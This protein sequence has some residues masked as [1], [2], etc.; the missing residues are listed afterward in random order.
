MASSVPLSKNA[1]YHF[2][3]ELLT[4]MKRGSD[5]P[6]TKEEKVE[7]ISA[8]RQRASTLRG[9]Y[10]ED[11]L[12]ELGVVESQLGALREQAATHHDESM[13]QLAGLHAKVDEMAGSGMEFLRSLDTGALMPRPAGQTDAERVRLLRALKRAADNELPDLVH[14]ER[15]R[16]LGEQRDVTAAR[17]QSAMETTVLAEAVT[18]E[19]LASMGTHEASQALAD[20]EVR[21][22]TLIKDEKKKLKERVKQEA[23]AGTAA[24]AAAKASAKGK[25]KTR[26]KSNGLGS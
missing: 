13:E 11:L 22:R 1:A 6:L 20:F 25:G 5:L 16:K 17:R 18:N 24:R 9:K 10:K 19:G 23:K 14:A 12:R 2:R 3:Q 15:L 7:R 26:S 8:L 4:G 21:M